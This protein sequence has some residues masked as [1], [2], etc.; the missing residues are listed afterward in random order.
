[1]AESPAKSHRASPSCLSAPQR[2]VTVLTLPDCRVEVRR[3]PGR[4]GS[5]G[6][7]TSAGVADLGEQPGC[8]VGAEVAKQVNRCPPISVNR[9]CAPGLGAFLAD[10][11]PHAF[12]P[13]GQVEQ[14][15]ELGDPRAIADLPVTVIGRVH[16]R[17]GTFPTAAQTSSVMQCTWPRPR[18]LCACP[19]QSP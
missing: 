3:R 13:G 10:D 18:R 9:S 14:A 19:W 4:S 16:T 7:E 17:A 2:K 8:P 5:R 12:R 1:V 15:G 6:W 11:D